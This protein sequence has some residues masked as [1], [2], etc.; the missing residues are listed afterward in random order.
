MPTD[1]RY[2]GIENAI[3]RSDR[4]QRRAI[5]SVARDNGHS[6]L[7]STH[8][9]YDEF[10]AHLR[11][12]LEAAR[13]VWVPEGADE[14]QTA[15]YRLIR[16]PDRYCDPTFPPAQVAWSKGVRPADE[17][18]DDVAAHT[19][20]WG[21]SEVSWAVSEFTAPSDTEHVL[22]A[23]GAALRETYRVLAYDFSD[24][25]PQ[26]E[27]PDKAVAELVSDEPR[28]RAAMFVNAEGWGS[29]PLDDAELAREL[30]RMARE[31]SMW[32]SFRVLVSFGDEPVATGGCTFV[33]NTAH[34]LGSVTLPGWRRRGA[35]RAVLAERLRLA[36]QN[37]AIMAVVKGRVDTSAP[38]LERAGFVDYGEE[39]RYRLRLA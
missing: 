22:V 29:Q 27:I 14:H 3:V 21:L 36:S 38:T 31:L 24:G 10:G 19:R 18:I 13:W 20:D 7:G 25:L 34:L 2:E 23:R 33:G 9:S 37:G 8:G 39:R 1:R 5:A 30:E 16:Y 4:W 11:Q 17:L 6:A 15:E 32:S 12:V 28:L 26:L 35:Y